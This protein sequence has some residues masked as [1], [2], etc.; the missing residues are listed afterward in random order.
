VTSS[1]GLLILLKATNLVCWNQWNNVFSYLGISFSTIFC[2]TG[3][4]KRLL[5][6]KVL[7]EELIFFFYIRRRINIGISIIISILFNITYTLLFPPS[8]IFP[9]SKYCHPKGTKF[10]HIFQPHQYQSKEPLKPIWL[11]IRGAR[12]IP[13]QN[14]SP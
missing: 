10:L 14:E 7:G 1:S 3:S 9:H 2:A 5:T 4:A 13:P 6:I 12:L 11:I 8:S